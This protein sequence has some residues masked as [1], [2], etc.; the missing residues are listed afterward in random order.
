[1]E[2]HNAKLMM[3]ILEKEETQTL[4]K[5]QTVNFRQLHKQCDDPNEIDLECLNHNDDISASPSSQ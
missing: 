4:V 2:Y 3:E 1:M 5:A